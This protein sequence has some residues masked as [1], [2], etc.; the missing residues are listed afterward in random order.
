M[1][2]S[3]IFHRLR[4]RRGERRGSEK[5]KHRKEPIEELFSTVGEHG[6]KTVAEGKHD[7]AE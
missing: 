7:T 5:D 1:P 4:A 3:N 2:G 6:L